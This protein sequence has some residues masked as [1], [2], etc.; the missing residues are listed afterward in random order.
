MYVAGEGSTGQLGLGTAV[1]HA[2]TPLPLAAAAV[3]PCGGAVA[4]LG[5]VRQLACGLRHTLLLLA[6]GS[7]LGCGSSN[8][9]QLGPGCRAKQAW[10]PQAIVDARSAGS[11]ARWAHGDGRLPIS[12]LLAGGD[13]SGMILSTGHLLLWGRGL[14]GRPDNADPVPAVQGPEPQAWDGD[15]EE[16]AGT[17][18]QAGPLTAETAGVGGHSSGGGGAA[19]WAAASLGWRQLVALDCRGSVWMSAAPGSAAAAASASP[20]AA[21]SAAPAAKAAA[22]GSGAAPA[23][24]LAAQPAG[25]QPVQLQRVALPGPALCVAAG[26]EH[27]AAAIVVQP[28][29]PSQIAGEDAGAASIGPHTSPMPASRAEWGRPQGQRPIIVSWGWGEHGQLGAEPAR[30]ADQQAGEQFKHA[31]VQLPTAE[32]PASAAATAATTTVTDPDR[33]PCLARATVHD[34]GGRVLLE[35]GGSFT[36]AAVCPQPAQSPAFPLESHSDR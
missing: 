3:G 29:R 5:R 16:E 22:A 6:D 30:C 10:H 36:I 25:P 28:S 11:W 24:H 33:H 32:G 20:A 15:G 7:L 21:A 23:G 2:A 9:R 14:A 27:F 8:H 34:A 4:A 31:I 18:C 19:A 13:R 1:Q 26:A 12:S 35:C 17:K